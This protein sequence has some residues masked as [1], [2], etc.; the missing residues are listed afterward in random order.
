VQRCPEPRE[1]ELRLFYRWLDLWRGASDIVTAMNGLASGLSSP[2]SYYRSHKPARAH[3]WWDL[4]DG[5]HARGAARC[6]GSLRRY[7]LARRSA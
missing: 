1:P 3:S 4:D 6:L 2:K 7:L 5:R